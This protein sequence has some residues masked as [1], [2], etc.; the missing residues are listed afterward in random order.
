MFTL[1]YKF[2]P[3]MHINECYDNITEIMNMLYQLGNPATQN[4]RF[5]DCK[6]NKM[7]GP[8]QLSC[9]S[10]LLALP[11]VIGVPGGTVQTRIAKVGSAQIQM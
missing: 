11:T 9:T 7:A 2:E 3:F 8:R 4:S 6:I 1:K 10:Q 5:S